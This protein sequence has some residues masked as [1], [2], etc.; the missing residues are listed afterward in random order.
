MLS[1]VA[2]VCLALGIWATSAI[3][4]LVYALWVDPY[5]YRDSNRLLNLGFVNTQG[6]DGTMWYSLADYIELNHDTNTLEVVAGRDGMNAVVTSG[7]P[8]SVSVVL[9]TPNAFNHFGVPAM[10]GRTWTPRDIPQPGAPPAVAVL[11][12]LFWTRH[13]NGQPVIGRTIELNRKPYTILGVVPPRFTWNDADVYIPLAVTPDPKHFIALMTHVRKGIGL[14][15][16]DAELQGMTERFARRNPNGY[17][18]NGFRMRVQTLNDFLLRRFGGTLKVL[19]AAVALLLLIGC[20]NVSILLLARAVRD[21]G[22]DRNSV[23]HGARLPPGR[24]GR[25]ACHAEWN[26]WIVR[27]ARGQTAGGADCCG[28]CADDCAS[29]W[30]FGGHSQLPCARACTAR[31]PTRKRAVAERRYSTRAL[32]FLGI[33]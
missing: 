22:P 9:F 25:C 18:K 13:F 7:L 21:F 10:I 33:A 29:H 27:R 15:A 20:A 8:E 4:S 28:N 11:S 12:Y 14:K 5:P 30:R 24:Y 16:V 19:M 26:S 2:I 32:R 23:R 17:P 3:T 6:R 1:S 31:I